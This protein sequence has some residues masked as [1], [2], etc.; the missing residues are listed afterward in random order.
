MAASRSSNGVTRRDVLVMGGTA[1][2]VLGLGGGCALIRGGAKHPI[3]S[4]SAS[5]LENGV[6]RIPVAELATLA[7]GDVLEVKAGTPY[8]DLLITQG[9]AAGEWQVITAHCTHKGCVVDFEA[10]KKEWAC[11][12]H[13]SR[14]AAYGAVVDGPAAEPL[15]QAPAALEGDAL[16]IQLGGL[17]AQA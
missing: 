14:F 13:G 2:A 10:P 15:Q 8:P 1:A 11:P 16:V 4:P 17:K 5:K 7:A 9:A 12:C 6:L 3:L